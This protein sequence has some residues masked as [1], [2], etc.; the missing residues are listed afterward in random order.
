MRAT[1]AGQQGK[2]TQATGPEA[3][4]A[5]SGKAAGA[6]RTAGWVAVADS[7][8]PVVAVSALMTGF[9]LWGLARGSAMGNDEVVSRYAAL[10]S[11]GPSSTA[12]DVV[13]TVL[14]PQPA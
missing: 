6:G 13:V 10:L 8:A 12:N 5:A 1:P 14:G 9:G 2:A 4:S 3:S 7:W 11:I